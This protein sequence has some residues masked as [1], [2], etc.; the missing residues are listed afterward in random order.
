MSHKQKPTCDHVTTGFRNRYHCYG[1]SRYLAQPRAPLTIPIRRGPSAVRPVP[2]HGGVTATR[3]RNRH[4][5]SPSQDHSTRPTRPSNEATRWQHHSTRRCYGSISLNEKTYGKRLTYEKT[6]EASHSKAHAR[7]R[8]KN[9]PGVVRPKL[10]NFHI[11]SSSA[12]LKRL[13]SQP[14]GPGFESAL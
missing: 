7:N 10:H 13:C 6:R 1:T 8:P 9:R 11:R 14:G 3:R 4:Q 2:P 5:C 12:G